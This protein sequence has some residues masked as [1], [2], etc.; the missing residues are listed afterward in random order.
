MV[1]KCVSLCREKFFVLVLL[2]SDNVYSY[3]A[4]LVAVGISFFYPFVFNH[5]Y[6]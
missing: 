2:F 3:S 4:F 5:F 6:L 1:I